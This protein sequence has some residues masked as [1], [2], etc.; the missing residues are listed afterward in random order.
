MNDETSKVFVDRIVENLLGL[1]VDTMADYIKNPDSVDP[2]IQIEWKLLMHL[3]SESKGMLP[4]QD[5]ERLVAEMEGALLNLETAMEEYDLRGEEF[6]LDEHKKK[7]TIVQGSDGL[8]R[9]VQDR[10][11]PIPPVHYVD[12]NPQPVENLWTEDE[13][14]QFTTKGA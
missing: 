13:L 2:Y 1:V 3:V 12:A 9:E 10:E 6:D 7:M 5:H 4:E 8:Y 14:K 11:E